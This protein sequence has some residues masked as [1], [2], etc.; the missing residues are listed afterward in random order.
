MFCRHF[1]IL[2]KYVQSGQF[3]TPTRYYEILTSKEQQKRRLSEENSVPLY[4]DRNGPI[5]LSPC[6]SDDNDDDDDDSEFPS[7]TCVFV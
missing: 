1:R 5:F 3:Q 6:D 4:K 2:A 7:G